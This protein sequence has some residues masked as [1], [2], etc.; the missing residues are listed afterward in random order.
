MFKPVVGFTLLVG[1]LNPGSLAAQDTPLHLAL[2]ESVEGAQP[3][4]ISLT[5]PSSGFLLL[6]H[7][8]GGKVRVMFPGRPT[9]SAELA[10]GEYN[11]ER[12]S[13]AG[14]PPRPL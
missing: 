8:A 1:M 7:V 4:D 2:V 11:V 3:W 10:A 6:V 14:S 12:A 9:R 5:T 13:P